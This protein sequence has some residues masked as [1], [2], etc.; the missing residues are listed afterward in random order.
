MSE[1]NTF[2]PNAV[3]APVVRA[4]VIG[5]LAKFVESAFNEFKIPEL[6]VVADNVN[7]GV[8]PLRT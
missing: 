1:A 3:G 2:A 6:G 7:K 8:P 5:S 4:T